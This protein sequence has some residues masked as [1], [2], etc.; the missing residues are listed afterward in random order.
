MFVVVVGCCSLLLFVVWFSLR[1][2][3]GMLLVLLCSRAMCRV[4]RLILVVGW[5]LLLFVGR[6]WILR[7]SWL[8]VLCCLLF[9]VC[10]LLLD[11]VVLIFCCLSCVVV[12]CS[13]S[14]VVLCAVL[15]V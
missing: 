15:V 14:F 10:G 7:C 13:L 3:V 5:C 2:N 4:R 6:S 8:F 11:V 9:D 12:C 1:I